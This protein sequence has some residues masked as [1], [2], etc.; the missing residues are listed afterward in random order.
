MVTAGA[1]LRPPA[2]KAATFTTLYSFTGGAG[3]GGPSALI[4][5]DG[6]LYG[7]TGFGG[8]GYGT[9]FAVNA[10][11]GSGTVLYNFIGAADGAYPAAGLTYQ[12]GTLFGTTASGGA[13]SDG[14]VFAVDLATGTESVLHSFTGGRDGGFPDAA[15]TE[16][17]G[18]LYGTT[19]GGG[20]AGYGTVFRIDPATGAETVLH[21]FAGGNDSESP[22]AGLTYQ[23]G[24][25]YGTTRGIRAEGTG[26]GDGSVFAIDPSTRVETVLHSF[27]GGADG[28]QPVDA[29]IY[30]NG[31]LYGTTADGGGTG[32]HAPK[33]GCGTVFAT[34]AASGATTILYSFTGKSRGNRPA[35]ALIRKGN[36]LYGTTVFGGTANLGTLFKVD[37]TT[38]AHKVLYSFSGVGDGGAPTAGLISQ[39][40]VFY[41]SASGGTS[42]AGAIFKFTP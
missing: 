25:F 6:T 36:N 19:S 32:C 29:P 1:A 33:F 42:N 15:L 11:T 16:Q 38:G 26:L 5:Q 20:D 27:M 39:G 34:D 18:K 8:T 13:S 37:A 3:N 40:G 28:A 4:Y 12:D 41:G 2:A 7:A 22:E 21:S 31:T 35:G 30:V 9:V 24:M 10:T 17:G 14:T 23:G